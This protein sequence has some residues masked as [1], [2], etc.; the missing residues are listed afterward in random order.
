MLTEV[1]RRIDVII[2]RACFA[3]SVY[4]ASRLVIHGDVMLNGKKVRDRVC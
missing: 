2:F 4:E 1:E 3:S